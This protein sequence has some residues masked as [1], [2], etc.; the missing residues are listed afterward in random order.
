MKPRALIP[1]ALLATPAAAEPYAMHAAAPDA[2][3][4]LPF[5]VAGLVVASVARLAWVRL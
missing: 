5:L 3:I 1:T 2:P 4:W